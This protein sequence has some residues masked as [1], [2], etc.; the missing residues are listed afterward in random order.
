MMNFKNAFGDG[1]L[2]DPATAKN[3]LVVQT[4]SM[5]RA[6]LE[7]ACRSGALRT[8]NDYSPVTPYV[9]RHAVQARCLASATNRFAHGLERNLSQTCWF[10][11]LCD[12]FHGPCSNNKGFAPE[13]SMIAHASARGR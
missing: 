2:E 3:F 1:E 4:K 5:R 10:A 6:G 8:V 9:Q 7:V 11:A 12:L 13:L